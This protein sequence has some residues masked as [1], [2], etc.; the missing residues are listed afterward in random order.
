MI[1]PSVWPFDHGWTRAAW[2]AAMSLVT[3]EAKEPIRLSLAAAI[4][5]GLALRS[6]VRLRIL[7]LTQKRAH[8]RFVHC[9]K[10]PRPAVIM[11]KRDLFA[12]LDDGQTTGQAPTK[13]ELIINTKTAKGLGPHHPTSTSRAPTR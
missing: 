5:G 6:M 2:T 7:P 10:G 9:A 12:C 13:Y 3:P 4:Q 8:F 11:K 1:W